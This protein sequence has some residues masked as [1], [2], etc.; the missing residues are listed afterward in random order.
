MVKTLVRNA[1]ID[2]MKWTNVL[3]TWQITKKIWFP[4]YFYPDIHHLWRL[5]FRHKQRFPQA[6]LFT[7]FVYWRLMHAHTYLVDHRYFNRGSNLKVEWT[8]SWS[9]F[10]GTVVVLH[11]EL[12]GVAR[13]F[14]RKVTR[15]FVR[16]SVC[17]TYV[18]CIGARISAKTSTLHP[19]NTDW[20]YTIPWNCKFKIAK[21]SGK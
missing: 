11:R 18:P 5:L 17:A 7:K 20:W 16:S 19:L 8:S 6:L 12:V 14:T 2:A 4:F 10:I 9:L 3:N 1:S 15:V 13:H 21:R